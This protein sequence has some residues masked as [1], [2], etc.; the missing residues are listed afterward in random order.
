MII[1]ALQINIILIITLNLS[2]QPLNQQLT[3][4]NQQINIGTIVKSGMDGT[5]IAEVDLSWPEGADRPI[6]AVVLK[7]Y[8]EFEKD[9]IVELAVREYVNT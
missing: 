1:L 8:T 5:K 3:I 7:D 2:D 9:P 4:N 6:V